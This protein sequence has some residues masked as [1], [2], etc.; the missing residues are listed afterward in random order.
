MQSLS[1]VMGKSLGFILVGIYS[2]CNGCVQFMT[3]K[4][5]CLHL[6]DYFGCCLE[7]DWGWTRGSRQSGQDAVVVNKKC[8]A[9]GSGADGEELRALTVELQERSFCLDQLK[10]VLNK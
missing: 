6:K 7:M 1:W 5:Y 8:G 4:I 2:G 9:A 3:E 10:G